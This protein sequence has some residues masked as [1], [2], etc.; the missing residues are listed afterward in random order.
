M[1]EKHMFKKNTYVYKF[2]RKDYKQI[3]FKRKYYKQIK[4]QEDGKKRQW[5]KQ[6]QLKNTRKY[7]RSE[8]LHFGKDSQNF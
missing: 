1:M 2:K 6:M 7:L 5:K 3:K 8:A 4:Q